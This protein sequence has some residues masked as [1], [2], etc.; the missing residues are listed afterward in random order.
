MKKKESVAA[1]CRR[2]GLPKTFKRG[3]LRYK[4][5][6]EKGIYWYWVSLFVRMRDVEKWGACISCGKEITLDTCDAGHFM[7]AGNCGR[8]LLF[9]LTNINAECK[10]CNGFDEAHLL[11]YAECLDQRYGVGTSRRLR[12]RREIY[13][14]GPPVKDWKKDEYEKKTE[15]LLKKGI[16]LGY[17]NFTYNHGQVFL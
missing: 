17:F 14:L 3:D 1:L 10:A 13:K 8:D 9:D 12:E 11:G 15:E 7:P 4:Q 5:P 2:W 6:P 16:A